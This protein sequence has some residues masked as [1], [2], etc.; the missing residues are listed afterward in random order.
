M[1][2]IGPDYLD[3]EAVVHVRQSTMTQR[4]HN[5]ESR[6]HQH[7]LANRA[8]ELWWPEPTVIDE[9]LGRS[10]G[11]NARPGFERL[12]VAICEGRVGI[13]PSLEASPLARNGRDRHTLP[14]LTR[15]SRL[16]RG[17]A[18]RRGCT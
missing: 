7:G 16:R 18:F 17:Y 9:D 1:G 15:G 10:G 2:R 6:G 3:P 4:R 12:F 13:V 8:R 14:T 11:G 5:H